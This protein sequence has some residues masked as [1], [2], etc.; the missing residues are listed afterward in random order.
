MNELEAVHSVF[1]IFGPPSV[2][3]SVKTEEYIYL[4]LFFCTIQITQDVD[5]IYNQSNL[6][7]SYKHIKLE[8]VNQLN[9]SII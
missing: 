1:F 6:M 2:D 7:F 9:A 8:V 3:K 5:M 4:P